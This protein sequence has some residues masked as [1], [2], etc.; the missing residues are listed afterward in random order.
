MLM[1]NSKY[2]VLQI[3]NFFPIFLVFI[4]FNLASTLSVKNTF[5]ITQN[6]EEIKYFIPKKKKIV[7]SN[8]TNQV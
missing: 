4:F 5:L 3:F 2:E 1:S 8:I 7:V 6:L